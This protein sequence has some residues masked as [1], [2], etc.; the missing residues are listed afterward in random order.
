MRLLWRAKTALNHLLRPLNMHL[1]SCTADRVETARLAD[2]LRIGHFS[3]PIF[4]IPDQFSR[5]DPTPVF[6]A[7][8]KYGPQL[9]RFNTKFEPDQ[10]SFANDYYT[11]P[12]A[13]VLYAMVRLHRPR[14]II[15]VGSGHSTLLFRQ[16]IADSGLPTR[17]I[18]IDPDPR[19]EIARHAD[20]VI[21]ERIETLDAVQ[22]FSRLER[23]DMLFIDSSHQ[24]KPG[25]D[26]VHLFLN[27]LPSLATGVI[28]HVH[29]I[30]L[31][32]EY[33]H[34]WVAEQ[35]WN[36]TEQYL[37]QALLQGSNEFDVLW[38]GHYLQQ[39]MSGFTDAFRFWRG[40]DA[41]SVWLRR[42]RSDN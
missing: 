41:R 23:N 34:E 15:E 17:L 37:L 25:N 1:D 42:V 13:E 19:R 11:S 18:A 5:C 9:E 30:F 33:P 38:A 40:G 39:F 21:L 16:A 12:D 35:R 31:P 27:V 10:F 20:E 14:C 2:L 8:E 26:V 28:V 3:R 29:D 22:L 24:I 32:F 4:A 7:L 36:W 6:D